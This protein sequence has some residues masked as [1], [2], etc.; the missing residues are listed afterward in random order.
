MNKQDWRELTEE[1][2]GRLFGKS[3]VQRA[4]YEGLMRTIRFLDDEQQSV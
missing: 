2:F 3:A 4:G 1:T